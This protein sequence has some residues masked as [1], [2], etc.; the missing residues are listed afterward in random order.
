MG[1]KHATLHSSPTDK[2]KE[3][4]ELYIYTKRASQRKLGFFFAFSVNFPLLLTHVVRQFFRTPKRSSRHA[5][6][7]F[8]KLKKGG[9]KREKKLFSHFIPCKNRMIWII[10]RFRLQ[11]WFLNKII[12]FWQYFFQYY[13]KFKGKSVVLKKER[14]FKKDNNDHFQSF[15]ICGSVCYQKIGTIFIY[16]SLLSYVLSK[17]LPKKEHEFERKNLKSSRYIYTAF[18]KNNSEYWQKMVEFGWRDYWSWK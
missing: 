1:Q 13:A 6:W 2:S 10:T 8:K 12:K 14:I 3:R 4:K 9:R 5:F 15:H 16:S 11:C 7:Y 18:K 17:Y